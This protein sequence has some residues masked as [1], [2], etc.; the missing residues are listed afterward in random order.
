MSETFIFKAC[1]WR[2]GV[3][4]IFRHNSMKNLKILPKLQAIPVGFGGNSFGATLGGEFACLSF[5]SVAAPRHFINNVRHSW[6]RF[7]PF[8]H[9]VSENA[10]ENITP[11]K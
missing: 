1:V 8:S 5:I 11:E 2:N 3:C 10:N 6:T 4:R 9:W 7:V